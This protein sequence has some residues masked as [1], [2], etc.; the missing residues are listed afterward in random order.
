MWPSWYIS[1]GRDLNHWIILQVLPQQF[2]QLFRDLISEYPFERN[3]VSDDTAAAT[4]IDRLEGTLSI[5]EEGVQL[6]QGTTYVSEHCS[7]WNAQRTVAAHSHNYTW[8]Q[9]FYC[10]FNCYLFYSNAT[11][12]KPWTT[13]RYCG[14]ELLRG[15]S[16]TW[17]EIAD[18][19]QMNRMESWSKFKRNIQLWSTSASASASAGFWRVCVQLQ[20]GFETVP[21][22]HKLS[23]HRP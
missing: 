18:A 1:A 21:M 3:S 16:Y 23:R 9:Q 6:L 5:V 4:L 17:N 8:C 19:M 20:S 7:T 11:E 2:T 12:W 13:K 15:C 10:P 14:V 22:K